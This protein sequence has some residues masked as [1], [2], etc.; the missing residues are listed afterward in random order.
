MRETALS[1]SLS[2]FLPSPLRCVESET[3]NSILEISNSMKNFSIFPRF[4]RFAEVIFNKV[5]WKAWQSF[6]DE[7]DELKGCGRRRKDGSQP[8]LFINQRGNLVILFPCAW[9]ITNA[10]P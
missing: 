5:R 8:S 4:D 9:T 2:P 10:R 6:F 3:S 1:S 7:E